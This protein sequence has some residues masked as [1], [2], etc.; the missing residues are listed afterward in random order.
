MPRTLIAGGA[1]Y[2][3]Q[4][5]AKVLVD[6]GREVTIFDNLVHGPQEGLAALKAKFI[7]GDI[8]DLSQVNRAL[9]DQDEA[10]LLAALVG[11]VACDSQPDAALE[12]NYLAAL[13]F[14]LTAQERGV[15]RFIFA[16]TDSC[17]GD[18]PNEKLTELST[19]APLSWYATL[20]AR[21]ETAIL[22]QKTPPH[23]AATV[24]RMGTLYGLAPRP[25]FDLVINLLAR[26]ATLKGQVKIFS[27]QQWRPFVHVF[28]AAR[29]YLLALNAPLELVAGQVFNV[30]SNAQNIQ[31]KDLAAQ[32]LTALPQTQI[33]TIHK[34]PDLRDYWVSFNKIK[35]VLGFEPEFTPQDGFLEIQKAILTGAIQDPYS[36][37]HINGGQ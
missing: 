29:A 22:A 35:T 14:F 11:E 30:G 3:G 34:P 21:A 26:E 5:L 28:D 10:I 7:E 9:K 24:L 25:R 12:V 31:F 20:K 17:Y 13:N 33:E 27:G 8:R 36:P 16:S 32:L 18:R 37:R 23:F 4:A 1:G 2:L 15:Q 6:S 19:L